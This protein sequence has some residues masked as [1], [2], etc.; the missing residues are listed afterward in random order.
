MRIQ[1]IV[2]IAVGCIVAAV[3]CN[4]EPERVEKKE[5]IFKEPILGEPSLTFVGLERVTVPRKRGGIFYLHAATFRDEE[6]RVTCYMVLY[7]ESALQC[8]PDAV[9]GTPAVSASPTPAAPAS[10]SAPSTG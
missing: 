7:E 1:I 5:L 9:L 6:R 10:T 3:G 2:C 4:A 8:I